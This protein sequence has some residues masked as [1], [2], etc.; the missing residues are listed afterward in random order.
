MGKQLP[1]RPVLI[2]LIALTTACTVQQT[3]VPSLTGP[4]EFALSVTV[5]VQPDIIT[6]DGRSQAL[7]SASTWPFPAG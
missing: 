3:K 7:S 2:A 5:D 6:R 1:R 4:S